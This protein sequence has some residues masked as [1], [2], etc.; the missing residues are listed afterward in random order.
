MRNQPRLIVVG[1]G[2]AITSFD[3]LAIET[4]DV[5]DITVEVLDATGRLP[6]GV[7]HTLQL[8]IA[9]S[10]FARTRA[11]ET[12][13]RANTARSKDESV[14][15]AAIATESSDAVEK[16]RGLDRASEVRAQAAEQ[17]TVAKEQARQAKIEA[18]QQ[19]R[20]QRDAARTRGKSEK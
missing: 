6:E 7:A 11:E 20:S 14:P 17:A 9:A 5:E 16:L 8:P 3:L 15:D 1:L 18:Q 4:A 10:E 2:L 12:L 13:L 19:I